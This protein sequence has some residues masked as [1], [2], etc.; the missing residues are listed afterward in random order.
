MSVMIAVAEPT[1][2]VAE[3]ALSPSSFAGTMIGPALLTAGSAMEIAGSSGAAE[4]AV[5]KAI[6]FGQAV[7]AHA[8]APAMVHHM[9]MSSIG[10]VVIA[11]GLC[12]G[13]PAY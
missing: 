10:A 12:T 13:C 2:T 8:V 9:M 3:P 7:A 1:F 4:S 6:S 11:G 5:V